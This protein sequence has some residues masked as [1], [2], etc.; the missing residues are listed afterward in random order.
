RRVGHDHDRGVAVLFELARDERAE[1]V[2]RRLSPVDGRGAVPR[3]PITRANEMKARPLVDAAMIAE[4]QLLHPLEDEDLDLRDFVEVDEIAR[5]GVGG[6]GT[7]TDAT[8]SSMTISTV[9]P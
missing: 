3:L 1:V 2:E 6:H 4:R 5:G 9:T 7:G 8:R